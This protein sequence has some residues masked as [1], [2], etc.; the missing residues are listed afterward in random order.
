VPKAY[1][2]ATYRVIKDPDAMAAYAKTSRP[3]LEVAGGR[4]VA[5]GMPAFAFE[6]GVKERVVLIEFPSVAA[7]KAAYDSPAY[8]AAHA[9]LG[10]SVD[11]D[12]RIV[13]AEG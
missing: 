13:E 4:V 5:R 12:I 1:W 8:Q 3:A 11:R 2:V 9:L 10:D 7:A 6:L